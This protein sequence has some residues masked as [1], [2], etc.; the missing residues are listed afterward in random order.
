VLA[1]SGLDTLIIL[2]WLVEH[3]QCEVVAFAADLGRKKS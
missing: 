2:K 1:Y 3:Y